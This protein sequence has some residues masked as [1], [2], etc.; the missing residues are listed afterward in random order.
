MYWLGRNVER[1]EGGIRLV[2]CFIARLLGE[3]GSGD[4]PELAAL[5]RAVTGQGQLRPEFALHSS[6]GQ[7]ISL[8]ESELLAF[9]FDDRRAGGLKNTLLAVQNLS[10]VVRD[11]ISIDSW[12]ILNRLTQAAWAISRSASFGSR[13]CWH[14]STK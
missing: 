12:R 7:R 5:L 3:S 1:A 8:M 4:Q 13:M 11:R 9:V 14:R 2:R 10:N 6:C